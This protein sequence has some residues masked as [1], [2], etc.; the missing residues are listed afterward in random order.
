MRG[1]LAEQQVRQQAR[2]TPPRGDRRC[3]APPAS[4]PAR[5]RKPPSPSKTPPPS[6]A[7]RLSGEAPRAAGHHVAYHRALEQER[8]QLSRRRRDTASPWASR[9]PRAPTEAPH[10]A[11][12]PYVSTDF[13]PSGSAGSAPPPPP[14]DHGNGNDQD[15]VFLFHPR[16]AE[17]VRAA[18]STAPLPPPIIHHGFPWG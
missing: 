17:P 11:Y 7:E 15:L 4:Q 6:S 12:H 1:L 14:R 5:T 13:G 16:P 9:Q 18:R 10:D 3:D 2:T 8:V